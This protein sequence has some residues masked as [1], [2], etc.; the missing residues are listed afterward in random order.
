MALAAATMAVVGLSPAAQA[1]TPATPSGLRVANSSAGTY[2]TWTAGG[3]STGFQV[4]QATDGRF[5]QN[6]R[7]YAD[8]DGRDRQL[9]PTGVTKGRTYYWRVRAMAGSAASPW[10]IKVHA[11]PVTDELKL[12][13]V[14]YN[15]I[16]NSADGTYESGNRIAAWSQRVPGVVTLLRQSGAGVIALQEAAGWIAQVKGPR[17]ADDVAARLGSNWRVAVTEVLPS[18]PGYFRTGVYILYDAS[19]YNAVAAGGHWNIGNTRWSAYQLLRDRASGVTFLMTSAHETTLTGS[20]GDSARET[21]TRALIA[22]ATGYA[23]SHGAVPVV[24]AGDFNSNDG[25]SH[26]FDGPGVATRAAHIADAFKSAASR[27]NARYDSANLYLRT[28]P[29]A[30]RSIDRIFAPPG[31]G[32]ASWRLGLD[33]SAGKFVGVIPSDHNPLAA[34]LTLPY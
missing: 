13:V 31:V 22:D 29:A 1:A 11:A 10:S 17:Q 7:I 25:H 24:Y 28:P 21:E 20:A 5:T 4:Q 23:R 2:L 15:V 30:G 33:L 6:V 18:Q 8:R 16:E 19:R 9:T 32:I 34:D 27:V 14:S 26:V 3:G 12:R